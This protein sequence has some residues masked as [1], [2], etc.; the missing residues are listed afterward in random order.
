MNCLELS[1]EYFF[2]VAE[3]DL[4]CKFPE[5]YPRLAAGLVGNGSE[6]FGYDDDLS[7]DHDWGIDFYIWTTDADKDRIPELHDWKNELFVRRPPKY[8]RTRSEYGARVGVMAYGEFYYGLIGAPEGPKT[9]NEWL[10]APEENFAM[11]VNGAVFIDGPVAFTKTRK[12]LLEYYP[13]DIRLKRVASKC[14]ALAQTGQYNHER[15][16]K[17]CDWVTLRTILS[18]FTDSAIAMAFLLNKVYRPYYKWAFRALGDLPLLGGETARL[19]L[20]IAHAG[21]FD[22]ASFLLRQKCIEELCELFVRELNAQGLSES[23]DPFL[24]AHGGEVQNIIG[25]EF[26]HSLPVQ[27][28]I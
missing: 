3:P 18:R 27:Y 7:R 17:R 1:R 4:R 10:R 13:E 14:M 2:S 9:L 15:T 20:T 16:A 24:A 12:Y 11:S 25:D 21:A 6:C 23:G 28:E 5:L 8:Q 22:D 19:L 26:L